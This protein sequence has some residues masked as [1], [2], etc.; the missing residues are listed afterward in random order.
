MQPLDTVDDPGS[1]HLVES[2]EPRYDPPSRKTIST[3]YLPQMFE[4]EKARVKHNVLD[5]QSQFIL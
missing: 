3:K 1:R 4:G 2:F 5:A